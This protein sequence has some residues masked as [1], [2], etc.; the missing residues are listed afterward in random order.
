MSGV[1]SL[2]EVAEACITH[3]VLLL[4]QVLRGGKEMSE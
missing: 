4:N 1:N 3:V 2:S